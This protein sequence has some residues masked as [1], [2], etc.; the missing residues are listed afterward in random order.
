MI[1]EVFR[2][3]EVPTEACDRHG[4]APE[5]Q[6]AALEERQEKA[7]EIREERAAE[8]SRG[9]RGWLR[10]IFGRRNGGGG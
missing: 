3:G 2:E 1:T 5:P 7:A 4:G 6:V 9:F 8:R 10:R